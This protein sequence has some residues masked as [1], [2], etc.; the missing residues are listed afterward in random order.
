MAPSQVIRTVLGDGGV[1][2]RVE[3]IDGEH[4]VLESRV[5]RFADGSFVEDGTI[6]YGLAG[7]V[8]FATVGRG[9]VGPSPMPGWV[10][11]AVMWSVTGGDGWFTGATGLITSNFIVSADGEVVDNHFTRIYLP[12]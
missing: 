11:G 7:T 1:E 2:S 9:T 8:S 10:H 12:A 6:T 4:A 5:E 3:P